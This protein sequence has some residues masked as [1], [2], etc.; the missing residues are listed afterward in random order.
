MEDASV[1]LAG[2]LTLLMIR[3]RSAAAA[4]RSTFG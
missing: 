4:R 2:K 3:G 1:D